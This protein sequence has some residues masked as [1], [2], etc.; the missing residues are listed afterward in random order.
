MN[1]SVVPQVVSGVM[2]RLTTS[3]TLSDDNPAHKA[4]RHHQLPSAPPLASIKEASHVR[5]GHVWVLRHGVVH[6]AGHAAAAV[7]HA[8]R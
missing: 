2:K 8:S 1:L 6:T 7:A 3:K 4:D 5:F